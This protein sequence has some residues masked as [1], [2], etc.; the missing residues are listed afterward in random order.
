MNPAEVLSLGESNTDKDVITMAKRIH[1]SPGWMFHDE[2]G[3]EL[4]PRLFSLLQGIKQT[5]RLT[6]ATKAAGMSYRHSWNLVEQA[7]VFFGGPVVRLEKGRGAELTPLGEKLLWA[8]ER[9]AARLKPQMENLASELN[10]EIQKELSGQRPVLRLH[11]SH[12]YAVAL[13]PDFARGFQ[14]D[15]QYK[16]PSDALAALSRSSCDLAGIHVPAEIR[17]EGLIEHYSSYLAAKHY[18]VIRFITRQQGLMLAPSNPKCIQGIADLGRV[19]V[20][21][22]NRQKDS[23]TR[24]LLDQLLLLE[25]IALRDIDGYEQEEF[26][27]TA[28]AAFVAAGMADAGFGVE[29]AA[30]QFGLEFLPVTKEHYLMIGHERTLS[31]EACRGF[32]A[33][34]RGAEFHAEVAALAGYSAEKCGEIEALS[35]YFL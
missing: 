16:P 9:V 33:Q 32:L 27:H 4:N 18:R 8:E 34:L 15:L 26:T 30:R 14:L 35:N 12:G 19:G 17:L 1:I 24:A 20:K 21:L 29:A 5:R 7:R 22:I 23:G 10:I 25:D 31:S 6:V 3:E 28:V 2:Q 13:L 11:A